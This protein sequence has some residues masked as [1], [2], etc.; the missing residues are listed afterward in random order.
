[1]YCITQNNAAVMAR[2]DTMPAN[3]RKMLPNP[4]MSKVWE[5]VATMA[6]LLG[7]PTSHST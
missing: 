5:T 7:I 2:P 1:M 6:C 4:L 3:I